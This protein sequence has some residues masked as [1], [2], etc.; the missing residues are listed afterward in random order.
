MIKKIKFKSY[1]KKSGSLTPFSIKKDIP[2]IVK[3]I[4][5]INGNKN[6][7]RGEHAHKRCSQFLY[8][9]SGRIE[10][11]YISKF[12]KNKIVLNSNE[13]KGILIKPKT[14]LKIKFIDKNSILMVF[15]DR[16]YEF[17]DYIEKFSDFKRLMKKK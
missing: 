4:F 15:C 11:N 12:F 1:K 3:R 5:I 13:K 6:S 2:I 17:T 9:I 14:W 7:I 8:P 16:E 10:I